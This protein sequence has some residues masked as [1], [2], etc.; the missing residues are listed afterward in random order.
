MFSSASWLCLL[1]AMMAL[2][3]VSREVYVRHLTPQ[4]V[5]RF[6]FSAGNSSAARVKSDLTEVARQHIFGT[7]PPVKKKVVEK[8]KI[9]EAPKTKLKLSL[10]GVITAKTQEES[11]AMVEIK[12]GETSVVRVGEDIGTTGAKL[13]A[14]H[15]DHILIEHRGKPEKLELV[16]PELSLTDLRSQSDNTISALNIN[17]AEFEALAKVNPNDVDISKLLPPPPVVPTEDSQQSAATES[18]SIGDVTRQ[19]IEELE[20]LERQ[21]EIA[22]LQRIIDDGQLEAAEI[23]ELRYELNILQSK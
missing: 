19:Q 4:S 14:V 20:Q 21:E 7:V 2:V 6:S 18:S 16:R 8:P 9:V 5:Q 13:T 22:E 10:T 17:V 15:R 12:R 11:R 3:A 23:E 1:L